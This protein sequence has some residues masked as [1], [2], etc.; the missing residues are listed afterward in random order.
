MEQ[1]IRILLPLFLLAS[2]DLATNRYGEPVPRASEMVERDLAFLDCKVVDSY[3]ISPR[4]GVV[5]DRANNALLTYRMSIYSEDM[6]SMDN[7]WVDQVDELLKMP[8]FDDGSNRKWRY[9][10]PASNDVNIWRTLNSDIPF[11]LKPSETAFAIHRDTLELYE[12]IGDS[13]EIPPL[14]ARSCA[15][16]DSWESLREITIS[17]NT[18]VRER[19]RE[20]K[21]AK[22]DANQI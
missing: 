15:L 14:T 1:M 20:A 16:V 3:S 8:V 13:S 17:F 10:K 4:L 5:F 9:G 2:C 6:P 11:D 7:H 18:A 22:E 21:K 12:W 19:I